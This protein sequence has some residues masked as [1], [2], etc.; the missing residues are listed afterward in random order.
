MVGNRLKTSPVSPG[1]KT[2]ANNGKRESPSSSKSM[3]K[4]GRGGCF[5]LRMFVWRGSNGQLRRPTNGEWV[6]TTDVPRSPANAGRRD[7]ASPE[8]TDLK[9]VLPALGVSFGMEYGQHHDTFV[10][11]N[12]NDLVRKPPGQCAAGVFVN[13]G[14]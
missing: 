3:G 2:S 13:S 4:T 1:W 5:F 7:M 9:P 12:K 6:E 14:V 8:T 11:L 10:V